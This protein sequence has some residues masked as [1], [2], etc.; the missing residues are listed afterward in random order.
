[1]AFGVHFQERSVV[2]WLAPV[3]PNG[4]FED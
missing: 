1:M 4:W 2:L 3:V